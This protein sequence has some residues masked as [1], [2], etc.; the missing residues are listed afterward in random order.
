MT[1]PTI[2]AKQV[3]ALIFPGDDLAP[4]EIAAMLAE[5]GERGLIETYDVGGK[6]YLAITG[7]KK[8]QR[9]DKPQPARCPGPIEEPT[10]QVRRPIEE[11]AA[12]ARDGDATAR[13]G[14]ERKRE[15]GSPD[16]SSLAGASGTVPRGQRKSPIQPAA[17]MK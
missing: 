3:K 12:N 5:L 10:A 1:A 13:D 14:E 7:W 9:I 16:S 11:C 15:E 2:S 4:D 17:F 8:H 6:R